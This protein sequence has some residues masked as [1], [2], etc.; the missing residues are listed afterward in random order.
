MC[1]RAH[2]LAVVHVA[3]DVRDERQRDEPRV[4]VDRAIHVVDV[5][6]PVA[7]LDDAELDAFLLELLVH[8]ERSREVQLVDHD[9]A[10]TLREVE[11]HHDDVFAVRGARG[12][13]DL[14]G[15][16]ADQLPEALL[17]IVLLVG[18][19]VA[20][21]F[22]R[23]SQAVRQRLFDGA[24]GERP[25]RVDGRGVQVGFLQREWE[26]GAHRRVENRGRARVL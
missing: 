10:P 17:E 4:L 11:A 26:V 22:T 23:T 9:V 3:V 8:V 13:R 24:R 16:R 15:R 1:Q 19:E 5:D 20:P 2:G 12:E 14:F 18:S 6:R 21:I 7:M 25:Q